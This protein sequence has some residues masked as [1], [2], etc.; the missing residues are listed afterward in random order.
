LVAAQLPAGVTIRQAGH[1]DLPTVID[2]LADTA[3]WLKTKGIVQWPDRF[4]PSVVISAMDGADLYVVAKGVE[5]V[6]T[7]TLQWHDPSFWGERDDAAFVHRLA[8]RRGHSGLGRSLLDWAAEQARSKGR[9]YLCLDCLSTNQRLCRYYEDLG[10]R[11]VNEVAG[12]SEHPHS[13]A[14]GAWSAILYEKPIP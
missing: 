1:G 2:I 11:A 14:H 5:V 8:V 3:A 9:T 4:P 13:A 10:F 7:I 12:P 6:A